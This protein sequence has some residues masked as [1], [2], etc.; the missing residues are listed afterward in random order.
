MTCCWY[1]G[2]PLITSTNVTLYHKAVG[3]QKFRVQNE[4]PDVFRKIT[5]GLFRYR[6]LIRNLL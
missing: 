1:N 2:A 4:P 3:A 5:S 6:A